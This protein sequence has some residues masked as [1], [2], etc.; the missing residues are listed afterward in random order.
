LTEDATLIKK[1]TGKKNIRFSEKYITNAEFNLI[2]ALSCCS[3]AIF[4]KR[5]L[6]DITIIINEQITFE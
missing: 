1:F 5:Q 4:S 6:I 2:T 3:S